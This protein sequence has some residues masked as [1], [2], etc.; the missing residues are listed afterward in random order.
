MYLNRC[1]FVM[2]IIRDCGSSCI[3]SILFDKVAG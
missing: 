2:A 3:F 1:D